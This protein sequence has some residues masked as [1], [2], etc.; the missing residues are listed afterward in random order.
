MN[1]GEE[2]GIPQPF[3]GHGEEMTVKREILYEGPSHLIDQLQGDLTDRGC[4]VT[5]T[6]ASRQGIVTE[7]MHAQGTPEAIQAGVGAFNRLGHPGARA[8]IN[9]QHLSRG[10]TAAQPDTFHA[11]DQQPGKD[12]VSLC[13]GTPVTV[14]GGRFSLH[15]SQNCPAC[16]TLASQR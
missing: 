8:F 4:Q 10:V 13:T 2:L 6:A 7:V 5:R 12:D 3:T 16:E 9:H 15:Y 1:L 14:P 11:V